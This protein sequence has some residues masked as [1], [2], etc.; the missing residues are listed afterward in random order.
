MRDCVALSDNIG[1]TQGSR[2]LLDMCQF[3]LLLDFVVIALAATALWRRS[4]AALSLAAGLTLAR[5]ALD[6]FPDWGWVPVALI[7]PVAL[8]R[9]ARPIRR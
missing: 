1:T 3:G 7:L 8:A 2:K 4:A 5:Y 6:G 9:A